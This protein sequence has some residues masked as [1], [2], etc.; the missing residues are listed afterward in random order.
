MVRL[1]WMVGL[2][3]VCSG[4][5]A[6]ATQVVL[7]PVRG[8]E[9]LTAQRDVAQRA[10]TDAMRQQGM[11]VVS[12]ADALGRLPANANACGAIDCAPTMLRELSIELAAACAVWLSPDA[13]EGTVFV[14]LIDDAGARFPGARAVNGGDIALAVRA[15]LAD[16]RGLHMLGPG[17][18]VRV[19]GQPEGAKVFVDGQLVGTVPYRAAMV[20]GRYELK[21]QAPGHKSEQQTLDI[22]LNDARVVDVEVGL[23]PGQ[24][25]PE[26]AVTTVAPI[27]SDA[28]APAAALSAQRVAQPADY[29]VGGTIALGGL[30]LMTI[31]P[32]RALAQ[33]HEC[34]NSD[35]SRRYTF[36]TRTALEVVGGALLVAGGAVVA[37]AWKP[38]AIEVVAQPSAA[39]VT[40][41]SQF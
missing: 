38:F 12:H 17:P 41:H 19:H 26:P 15:A 33:H 4:A 29:I 1:I 16:A 35:C 32:V 22:P 30:L 18:W 36:G 2:W 13:P 23:S 9:R 5:M 40:V 8:D 21:V 14:T 7:L 24:D 6:Q 11:A 39:G 37:L 25:P 3:L 10:L 31:D 34:A 27:A 28:P 20:A